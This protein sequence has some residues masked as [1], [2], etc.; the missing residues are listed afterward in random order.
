MDISDKTAEELDEAYE[1]ENLKKLE[2]VLFIAG[3][4]L[5]LKEIVGLTGINPIILRQLLDKLAEKYSRDSS[6]IEIIEKSEMWKM[7]VKGDYIDFVNKIATGNTEFT[8]AEQETLA[9]IA[10]KQP[11]K[12][13]VI[14][15]IRGNKA[16]E[17]IK[18]F[19]DIGL[20]RTKKTGHT[21]ELNLSEEFH[22]YFSVGEMK[23]KQGEE[24]EKGSQ[25]GIQNKQAEE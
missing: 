13:S 10:Y 18:K 5:S 2:A 20:L 14:V 19:V 8:K 3:R 21:Q 12:Q 4:F 22:D 23:E 24:I 16:Y 15:N 9:I 1:R 7:D 25:I 17:H 11:V 6:A